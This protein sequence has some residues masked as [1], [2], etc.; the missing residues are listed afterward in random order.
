MT[1][2]PITTLT[3]D[4]TSGFSN[5]KPVSARDMIDFFKELPDFWEALA[6]SLGSLSGRMS[7]EMPLHPAL[8]E[9]VR[10]MAGTVA[11]LRDAADEMNSLFRTAHEKEIQRHEEPRPGEEAWD[12]RE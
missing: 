3:E 8:A 2:S 7:D 9:S 11:G 6:G 5:F 12:V 1:G 4:T 10:E